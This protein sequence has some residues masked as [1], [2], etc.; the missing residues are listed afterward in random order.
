ML[1][2]CNFEFIKLIPDIRAAKR[3]SVGD[4]PTLDPTQASKVVLGGASAMQQCYERALKNNAGLQMQAGLTVRLHL[5]VKP[6]GGVEAVRLEPEVDKSMT[7]CVRSTAMRW[8]WRVSS[9]R[10]RAI[11]SSKPASLRKRA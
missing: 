3:A 10:N 6:T 7:D 5:T 4:G 8:K 2:N 9:R 1:T 11:A